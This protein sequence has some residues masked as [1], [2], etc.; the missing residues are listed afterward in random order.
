MSMPATAVWRVSRRTDTARRPELVVGKSPWRGEL[1][2]PA[3]AQ[4]LL[5][6]RMGEWGVDAL[7]F[8]VH[9]PHYLGQMEYPRAAVSLLEQLERG[10]RLTIDL[11]AVREAAEV[12]ETEIERYLSSHDEV[13]EVVRGLE[14]QYDAFRAAEEAGSSLLASDEPLPTGEEIGNAFEQFLAGLDDGDQGGDP[15]E[16]PGDSWGGGGR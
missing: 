15:G 6:I 7:G 12:T 3:S 4:S 13:N 14:Q 16:A 9:I 10:G 1:R 11:T 8:V 2:V 5:E